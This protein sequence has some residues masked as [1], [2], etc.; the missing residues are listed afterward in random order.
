[1]YMLLISGSISLYFHFICPLIMPPQTV[2]LYHNLD[3]GNIFSFLFLISLNFHL[4]VHWLFL[5]LNS[6]QR[7]SFVS[8]E[9]GSH[10]KEATVPMFQCFDTFVVANNPLV[11]NSSCLPALPIVLKSHVDLFANHFW[12]CSLAV[13][14]FVPNRLWT[15]VLIG[16]ADLPHSRP[17]I[18]CSV[19]SIFL[20]GQGLAAECAPVEGE[21]GGCQV[22][23]NRSF[24]SL[25]MYLLALRGQTCYQCQI[26][27]RW[28]RKCICSQNIA[29]V[30]P[31]KLMLCS[32]RL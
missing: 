3:V 11:A 17:H 19:G 10:C 25:C 8:I 14:A 2:N 7:A 13:W 31:Y 15:W 29:S 27:N 4:I 18:C 28:S 20:N 21:G 16:R 30:L 1:M 24:H 22:M 9:C 12:I 23:A 32:L 6:V 26:C 5:L